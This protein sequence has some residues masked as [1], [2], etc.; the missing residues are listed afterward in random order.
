MTRSSSSWVRYGIIGMA[1]SFVVNMAAADPL[2]DPIAV[3]CAVVF[4]ASF[5]LLIA[6]TVRAVQ[7]KRVA[8]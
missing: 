5:A 1:V 7:S 4:V 8:S 2:P 3:V 6:G